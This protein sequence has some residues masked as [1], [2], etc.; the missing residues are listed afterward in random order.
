MFVIL[1]QLDDISQLK[2]VQYTFQELSSCA[3]F[4]PPLGTRNTNIPLHHKATTGMP[5][6]PT[7]STPNTYH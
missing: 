4:Q 3:H 1:D 2:V 6:I 5:L 7:H